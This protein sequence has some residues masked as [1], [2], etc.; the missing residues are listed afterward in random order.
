MRFDTRIDSAS[1]VTQ[2]DRAALDSELGL[3]GLGH[4]P[5][6]DRRQVDFRLVA[7]VAFGIMTGQGQ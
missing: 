1:L 7:R 3:Q 4:H 5:L 6:D 2:D